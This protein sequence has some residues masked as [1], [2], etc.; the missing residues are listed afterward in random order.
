MEADP[1]DT[2][3]LPTFPQLLRLLAKIDWTA[4]SLPEEKMNPIVKF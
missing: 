1:E 4:Q 2:F 3:F